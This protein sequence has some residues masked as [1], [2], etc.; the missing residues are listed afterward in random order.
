MT[1]LWIA[2]AVFVVLFGGGFFWGW[3][4]RGWEVKKLKKRY[5][6]YFQLSI[7]RMCDT[8]DEIEGLREEKIRLYS[9]AIK[10]NIPV[11]TTIAGAMVAVMGL[12]SVIKGRVQVKPLQ[13]YHAAMGS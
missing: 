1:V 6:D 9:E 2:V 4:V 11:V 7:E 12:E 5:D 10:Y 13:D 8:Q 3:F